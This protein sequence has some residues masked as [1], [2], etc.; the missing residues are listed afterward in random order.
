MR[1]DVCFMIEPSGR[2]VRALRRFVLGAD[3]TCVDDTYHEHRAE[4]GIEPEVR[5]DEGFVA[6]IPPEEYADDSR[7]GV[8]CARCEA[9]TF[10][11][12]DVWQVTQEPLYVRVDGTPGEWTLRS[13]PPGA[14]WDAFWYSQIE[15]WRGPDGLSLCVAL[16]PDG[17][18]HMWGIDLPARDGGHWT[19]TGTPPRISAAPSILTPWYHGFLTDGVLREC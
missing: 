5:T 15:N 16:P 18:Q 12:D 19:R 10:T 2:A 11:D 7:W 17:G 3:R 8:V 14:M 4:I 13:V 6:V 9:Y 1:E